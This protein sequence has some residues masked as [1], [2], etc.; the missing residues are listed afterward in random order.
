MK[1]CTNI[2]EL[3]S[4]YFD[5]ELTESEKLKVEE[6]I[7][8]C[9]EC[10]V[11]L[12]IYREISNTTS[13]SNVVVPEGLHIGVM[14]RIQYESIEGRP[15]TSEVKEKEKKRKRFNFMVTRLAP[16]A[17]CLA[18]VLVAWQLWGNWDN[19]FVAD[20]AAEA[21]AA[22]ELLAFD[23]AAPAAAPE[24]IADE[25]FWGDAVAEEAEHFAEVEEDIYITRS[26]LYAALDAIEDED[27]EYENEMVLGRYIFRAEV[28]DLDPYHYPMN[29]E[30]WILVTNTTYI[31]HLDIGG[32][33]FVV[34]ND[35][36][37]ILDIN[38]NPISYADIPTGAIVEVTFYDLIF[39]LYPA[40]LFPSLIKIVG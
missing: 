38:S 31:W 12:E 16:I 3:L 11:I 27:A 19:L 21:P 20:F 22:A 5:G 23:D 6:H 35:D 2:N 15:A 1:E 4:A 28:L 30:A 24:A 39:E 17:A 32:R 33:F 36:V 13:V 26:S 25:D 8:S 40:I 34:I 10:S 9:D 37:D 7:A 14:N 18:V 29:Y